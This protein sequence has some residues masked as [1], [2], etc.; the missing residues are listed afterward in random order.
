MSISINEIRKKK[1][2]DQTLEELKYNKLYTI[3]VIKN[4]KDIKQFRQES[5]YLEK[6]VNEIRKREYS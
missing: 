3:Q 2:K 1:L 6:I 4:T 5:K